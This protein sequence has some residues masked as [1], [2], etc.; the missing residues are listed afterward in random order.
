MKEDWRTHAIGRHLVD[1]PAEA[2]T[3]EIH[4]YNGDRIELLTDIKTQENFDLLVNRREQ[5]LRAAKH[6][7]HGSMFVER[8]PQFNGSVTLVS[9]GN[10]NSERQYRFESYFKAGTKFLRYPGNVGRDRKKLILDFCEDLAREWREIPFGKLPDGV[11]FVA[12]DTILVDKDFNRESWELNIQLPDRPDVS[13][14]LTAYAQTS[15]GPGLRVRAGG[16]LPALLGTVAGV[17]QLR[18]RARPVGPIEADEILV[19]GT[20]DGKRTYGFKWEAPGKAYSLAEPN[21]N[22]SLRVGESAY[23]TN[24]ESFANDGEALELWD[25]VVDSIRLRPGAV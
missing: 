5:E 15:I 20:Q 13:F 7:L 19:A 18:N 4:S 9:W 6:V 10:K 12:G 3:F 8:V 1:L 16:I 22:A 21:L 14:R 2:I 17:G 11:G 24:K 23:L 25:G